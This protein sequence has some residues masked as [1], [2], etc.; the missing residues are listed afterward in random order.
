MCGRIKGME[1]K[2][3]QLKRKSYTQEFKAEA[4]KLILDGG[5][6]YAEVAKELGVTETS[7][8][9]WVLQAQV[10]S[11]KGPPGRL[12]T[13][14]HAELVQLRKE[15]RELRMERDF[16]KKATAFFARDQK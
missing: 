16:L 9:N 1:N 8:R 6:R 10:D 12:T 13:A 14:E 7:L 2:T 15:C 3:E 11:G 4:V 5:R